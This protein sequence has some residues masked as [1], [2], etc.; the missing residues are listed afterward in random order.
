MF[1]NIYSFPKNNEIL[2]NF[3]QNNTI[4]YS[5]LEN[6][7]V[8][9]EKFSSN[10]RS[11]AAVMH[12]AY[13][14][15]SHVISQRRKEISPQRHWREYQFWEDINGKSRIQRCH[16]LDLQVLCLLY[17]QTPQN[18]AIHLNSLQVKFILKIN[19][20]KL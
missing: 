10:V 7:A 13:D 19:F 5:L 3:L 1:S 11:S 8:H 18:F 20:I 17:H 2:Y 14:A 9:V 15:L 12:N 4:L 6:N 16:F